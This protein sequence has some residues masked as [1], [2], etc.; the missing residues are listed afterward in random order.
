[1]INRYEQKK[2]AV[3]K[4]E[5][6]LTEVWNVSLLLWSHEARGIVLHTWNSLFD[7][8]EILKAELELEKL[9]KEVLK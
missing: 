9:R 3:E 5:D 4:L 7:V 8:K 6:V 1:M 2:Q